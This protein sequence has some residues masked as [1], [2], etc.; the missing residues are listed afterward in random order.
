MLNVIWMLTV[1]KILLIFNV[2]TIF[3]TAME[4]LFGLEVGIN[5]YTF[6]FVAIGLIKNVLQ[7]YDSISKATI[8]AI[9]KD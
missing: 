8:K 9:I 3:I 7:S 4:E 2:D 6:V 1:S 5:T